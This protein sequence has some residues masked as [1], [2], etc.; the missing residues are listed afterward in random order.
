MCL[1]LNYFF[2][3]DAKS[4][5]TLGMIG[6]STPAG[7]AGAATSPPPPP[8]PKGFGKLGRLTLGSLT[9]AL[10]ELSISLTLAVGF[11]TDDATLPSTLSAGFEPSSAASCTPVTMPF[12]TGMT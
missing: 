5:A 11:F 8:P 4:S 6:G 10:T 1:Y 2:P 3:I 12:T 9:L 7:T